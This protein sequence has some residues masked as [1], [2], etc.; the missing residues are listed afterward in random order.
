VKETWREGSLAGDPGGGLIYQGPGEMDE[1][2]SRDG[3]LS[4]KRLCGGGLRGGSFP[5]D[6]LRY[7]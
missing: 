3:G 7:V 1:G 2:G 5:V 4:L 6:P